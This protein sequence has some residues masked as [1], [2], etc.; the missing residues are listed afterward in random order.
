MTKVPEIL[1]WIWVDRVN[2]AAGE[3]SS[4]AI[5]SV[6]PVEPQYHGVTVTRVESKFRERVS[7]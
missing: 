4:D 5:S 6:I 7:R 2:A 3:K 1:S